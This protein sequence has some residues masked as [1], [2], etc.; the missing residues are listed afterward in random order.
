MNSNEITRIA[1]L[2]KHTRPLFEGVHSSDTLPRGKIQFFPCFMIVNTDK[3]Y[4]VGRHWLLIMMRSHN[5]P[6]EFFDS[7][8]KTPSDYDHNIEEFLIANSTKGYK[9]S[10]DRYQNYHSIN[11][12][13]F[14]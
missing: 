9:I 8:G 2:H 10:S 4:Q 13:G 1:S 12:G 7:L 6:P 3:A 11:W 5:D 14:F